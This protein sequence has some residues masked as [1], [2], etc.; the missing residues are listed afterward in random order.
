MFLQEFNL[1]ERGWQAL[2]DELKAR[3]E[4]VDPNIMVTV[5]EVINKV[6]KEGDKALIEYTEKFDKVHLDDMKVTE[7]E[8]DKY[9]NKKVRMFEW[10]KSLNDFIENI[11]KLDDK[12]N[13]E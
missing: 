2:I 9:K 12:R 7:E 8:L 10:Y 1:Q 13:Y 6:A 11:D 4:E 5:S 3:E